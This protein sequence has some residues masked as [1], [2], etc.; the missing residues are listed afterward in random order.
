MQL[1]EQLHEKK[2]EVAFTDALKAYLAK[3]GFDPLMVRA[4]HVASDSGH[5]TYCAGRRASVLDA[6][7]AAAR[8]PWTWMPKARPGCFSTKPR[9]K[10]SPERRQ[11]CNPS[12]TDE[13]RL[14]FR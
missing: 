1:E 6:S 11:W 7:R 12:R 13:V 14:F 2:V 8:L 9:K 4:A 10:V 5:D 3:T